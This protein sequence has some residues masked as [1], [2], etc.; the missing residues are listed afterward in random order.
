[1]R[2][3]AL[4]YFW[5]YISLYGSKLSQILL[6]LLLLLMCCH[7]FTLFPF[8]LSLVAIQ[9]DTTTAIF[10]PTIHNTIGPHQ[11]LISIK[12]FSQ[13]RLKLTTTS[14]V[15][16][17]LQFQTLFISYE[18]L[19][20]IDGTKPCLTTNNTTTPNLA[21]LICLDSSRSIDLEYNYQLTLFN[22]HPFYCLDHYLTWSLD[23]PN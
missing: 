15:S 8:L 9:D 21:Y 13:V 3:L 7:I 6:P 5:T 4:S 22:N 23:H 10:V 18:L 12:A 17:K 19:G 20:Y 11:T 14:Y 1:M 16:W 2:Y